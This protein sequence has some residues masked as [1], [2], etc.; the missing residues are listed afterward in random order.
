MNALKNTNFKTINGRFLAFWLAAFGVANHKQ[1]KNMQIIEENG[2]NC[3]SCRI[4]TT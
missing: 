1:I 4:R 3:K 2:K